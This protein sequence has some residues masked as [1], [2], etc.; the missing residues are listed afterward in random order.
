MFGLSDLTWIAFAVLMVAVVIKLTMAY[1][2]KK[3]KRKKL[4]EEA[5]ALPTLGINVGENIETE[6][7]I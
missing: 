2:E 1:K 6:E 3:A 4:E 7:K 5:K